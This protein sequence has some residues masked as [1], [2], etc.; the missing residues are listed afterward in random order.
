MDGVHDTDSGGQTASLLP[1]TTSSEACFALSYNV[2]KGE[3][4]V[5]R[6]A[7]VAVCLSTRPAAVE[8]AVS[9][10]VDGL[11]SLFL[12]FVDVLSWSTG[13]LYLSLVSRQGR[14]NT[15]CMT[16]WSRLASPW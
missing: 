14:A 8:A 15:I 2:A 6:R 5:G 1:A 3:N 9:L 13:L 7:S 4:G 10:C 12:C 11:L 16:V